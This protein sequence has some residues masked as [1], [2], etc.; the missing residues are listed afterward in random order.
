MLTSTTLGPCRPFALPG[1]ETGQEASTCEKE[2]ERRKRCW[3]KNK[4][5]AAPRQNKEWKEFLQRESE[6]LE[7]MNTELK[8]QMEEL[9]QERQRL[10]LMHNRHRPTCIIRTSSIK[11]PD[12]E[13]NP[14][15][16]QLEKK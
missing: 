1:G 7:L 2:E 10:I 13:G 4:V 9:K 16:E 3:E 6:W 5:A 14:L 11:T 15:L 12:S 8:T